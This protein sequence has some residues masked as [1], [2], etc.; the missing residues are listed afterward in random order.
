MNFVCQEMPLVY[1]QRLITLNM[2]IHWNRQNVCSIPLSCWLLKSCL[3]FCQFGLLS[4]LAVWSLTNFSL[5]SRRGLVQWFC[6]ALIY[7]LDTNVE[8]SQ[9]PLPVFLIKNIFQHLWQP[10]SLSLQPSL[11]TIYL[12]PKYISQFIQD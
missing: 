6:Y 4:A 10:N 3:L 11:T 12:I 5:Y 7:K 2:D 9:A 8:V 1:L